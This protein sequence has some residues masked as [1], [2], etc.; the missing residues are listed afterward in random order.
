MK[1]LEVHLNTLEYNWKYTIHFR[2]IT[3]SDTVQLLCLIFM[4]IVSYK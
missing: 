3:Q 4:M 1:V 2:F